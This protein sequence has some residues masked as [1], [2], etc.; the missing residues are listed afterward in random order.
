VSAVTTPATASWTPE[1]KPSPTFQGRALGHSF[2]LDPGSADTRVLNRLAP[3]L[4]PL[5]ADVEADVSYTVLIRDSG[6]YRL[7]CDEAVVC[8]QQDAAMTARF[9]AWHL[10]RSAVATARADHTVLHAAAARRAGCTVVLA[11][12]EGCGKTTTV[13]GL[14]TDGW[15]YVTDEA[16]ALRR[17]DLL[18]TPYPKALSLDPGSW[19]LFPQAR[20]S[21][22]DADDDGQWQVPA[23]VLGARTVIE[24]TTPTTVVLPRFTGAGITRA[25]AVSPAD[26]V[27]RLARCTFGFSEG[28][29]DDLEVLVR[30]AR[31]C[32]VYSLE[33]AD[34][35]SAVRSIE[36]LAEVR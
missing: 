28:G 6:R 26:A 21:W 27:V 9:L 25:T 1:T 24:R 11:A 16:V 23:S 30:T 20:P 2:R 15:D 32:P 17:E 31:V 10:N 4:A 5:A 34:L 29:V 13:G 33:I 8:D 22:P 3:V 19:R 18:I 12:P 35:A 7:A 36:Q 14:L